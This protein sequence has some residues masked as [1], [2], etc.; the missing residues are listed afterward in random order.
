MPLVRE[1]LAF[2]VLM[3]DGN[4]RLRQMGVVKARSICRAELR[5]NPEAEKRY[6]EWTARFEDGLKTYGPGFRAWERGSNNRNT[7]D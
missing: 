4:P 7:N 2:E 1:L 6:K 5:D 3:S